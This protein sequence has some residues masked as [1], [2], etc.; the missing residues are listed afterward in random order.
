[1]TRI[2]KIQIKW[3]LPFATIAIFLCIPLMVLQ[4]EP[5]NNLEL[6]SEEQQWLEKHK[7]N[8]RYAPSPNY[9]PIGFVENGK[10]KG[11][12]AEYIQII[13]ERLNISFEIVYLDSW[14]EIMKKARLG[15]LDMVGN[16][17]DTPARR[18]F[19]QFTNPYIRIP[20]SIIIRND[21]KYFIS[22]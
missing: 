8:I 2:V 19:L 22:F 10:P 21:F 3:L 1:M 11:V 5:S 7:D 14:N 17:Q 6:T 16:I 12:T 18:K 9:P 15:E 13:E 4:A 20:N